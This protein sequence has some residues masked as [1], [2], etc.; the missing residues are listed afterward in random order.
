MSKLSILLDVI[1]ILMVIAVLAI[2]IWKIQVPA[3]AAA[4]AATAGAVERVATCP[5]NMVCIPKETYNLSSVYQRDRAVI[6]DELMPPRNRTD[7]MNH[8][9]FQQGVKNRD[10]GQPTRS[11]GYDSYRLVGYLQPQNIEPG[12]RPDTWK[13]FA[14]QKDRNRSDFYVSS[15]DRNIDVKIPLSDSMMTEERLTDAMSLPNE[16]TI[17]HPMLTSKDYQVIELPKTDISMD[18][19]QYF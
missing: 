11:D 7:T 9:R 3:A 2:L 10:Y 14:R 8:A 18:G 16:V 6:A 17:Q 4:P 12:T 1:L 19:L 15:A 13:L 5:D